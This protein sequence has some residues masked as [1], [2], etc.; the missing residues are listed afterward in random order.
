MFDREWYLVRQ[1][2]ISFNSNPDRWE[3][4]LRSHYLQAFPAKLVDQFQRMGLGCFIDWWVFQQV[5]QWVSKTKQ[6]EEHSINLSGWSLND[7][8]L[9]L[10]HSIMGLLQSTSPPLSQ[11][12]FEIS[13]EHPIDWT[14]GSN[15]KQ[16]FFQFI[17]SVNSR[18]SLD[19]FGRGHCLD[20]VITRFRTPPTVKI[21]KKYIQAMVDGQKE[22]DR[23]RYI[24]NLAHGEG[25]EVV[26]EGIETLQQLELAQA[27]GCDWAQGF[28]IDRPQPLA[29]P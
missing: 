13:E 3:V 25:S 5:C 4:L 18:I 20:D 26:A 28:Y 15:V 14:S 17:Q 8:E 29:C 27:A 19:D 9:R 12:G 11:I 7:P 24:V 21:D 1:R 10:I 6:T 16:N 2:I 22:R 23:I